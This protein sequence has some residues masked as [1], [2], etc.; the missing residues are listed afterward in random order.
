[1]P[2]AFCLLIS[3]VSSTNLHRRC[4]DRHA[5][6]SQPARW[7]RIGI[8]LALSRRRA[9]PSIR[10]EIGCYGRAA[11]RRGAAAKRDRA[12]D[13][14]DGSERFAVDRP[15]SSWLPFASIETSA[16]R[17]FHLQENHFARSLG[18]FCECLY[19]KL[20]GFAAPILIRHDRSRAVGGV[21]VA[22]VGRL[23]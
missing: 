3:D 4:R 2:L 1:M 10:R 15:S 7:V 6:R 22:N 8:L 18:H 13:Y 19:A 14:S 20:F 5:R 21:K 9:A 16:G 23:S 12:D 11:R 17:T